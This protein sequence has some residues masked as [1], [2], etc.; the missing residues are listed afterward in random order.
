MTKPLLRAAADASW[1][2]A[3]ALEEYAEG[4]CF[5]TATLS[6]AAAEIKRGAPR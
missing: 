2:Q 5:S 4:N 1:E 6:D 3:L